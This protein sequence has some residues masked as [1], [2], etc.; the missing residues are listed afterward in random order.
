MLK[1]KD[2]TS[3]ALLKKKASDFHPILFFFSI[4][5][6]KND[7]N[8][9][10]E[11]STVYKERTGNFQRRIREVEVGRSE[12]AMKTSDEAVMRVKEIL[13]MDRLCEVSESVERDMDEC[14]NDRCCTRLL[15][16][17]ATSHI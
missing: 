2:M 16:S 17:G 6:A 14:E 1:L 8:N 11:E 10:E 4:I 12:V 7:N 15:D 3:V 13:P 5:L 9:Q